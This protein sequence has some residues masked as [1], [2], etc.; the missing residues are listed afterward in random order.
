MLDPLTVATRLLNL[1]FTGARDRAAAAPEP[2]VADEAASFCVPRLT[3]PRSQATAIA[4]IA[5]TAPEA[6][7][8]SVWRLPPGSCSPQRRQKRGRREERPHPGQRPPTLAGSS[9]RSSSISS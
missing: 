6:V 1:G 7:S 5:S 2:A 4:P 8:A 3:P 9:A